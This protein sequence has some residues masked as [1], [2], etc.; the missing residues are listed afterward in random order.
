MPELT[1]IPHIPIPA[2]LVG[3]VQARLAYV[4]ENIA[5]AAIDPDGARIALHLRGEDSEAQRAL[6]E[7]KVHTVVEE[8]AA[9]SFQPRVEILEDLTARPHAYHQD[10]MPELLARGEVS[11]EALGMFTFGPLMTRLIEYFESRFLELADH[12]DAQPYRFPT[13][14]SAEKLARVDYFRAF[15]HSLTFATHL[16]EDLEIINDFAET[17]AYEG[18]SL[19]ADMEN[20][21]KIQ[22]M[23]SPAVCYHLYFSLADHPLPD[24][25]LIATAVGTCFRYESSNLTSLE[26]LWNFTMREV[27]FVGSKDF[28]LEHREQSREFMRAIFEELGLVYHVESANDPFFVGEFRKQAMFQNAFQLKY[29][30]RAKLPF[31]GSDLA[32]GSY[33]YH[34]DFF[35]RNLDIT[36]PDGKPIHTACTA[37]GLE[38]MAY[39][40]LAQHGLDPAGWP[41]PVRKALA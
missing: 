31:K 1:I 8:M 2:H 35:G 40:F 17:A 16:R 39:A 22:A 15:P 30:I 13:L 9:G 26:R 41:A 12:F 25:Q 3:Q 34:Q 19:N 32:V 36:L 28:V 11:E 29:E 23:L 33:N 10:P 24:G 6:I 14:M 5:R 4:D 38:R 37:F 20:F 21:A 7:T 18:H 27:I